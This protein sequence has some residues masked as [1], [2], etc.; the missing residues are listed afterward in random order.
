MNP[1]FKAPTL[2]AHIENLAKEDPGRA[3]LL[4]CNKEGA[5][6]NIFSRKQVKEALLGLASFFQNQGVKS[7]DVIGL[8]FSNSPLLL[9]INWAAWSLGIIT[10]PLDLKRDTQKEHDFKLTKSSASLLLCQKGVFSEEQ[11]KKFK[12]KVVEIDSS[13]L[14]FRGES[15]PFRKE[16]TQRALILFTSGTTSH[17]R[18]VMLS[19]YSLVTNADSIRKWFK[20]TNEDRFMV[21]LPLHHINSTTF[22]LATLLAGGSIAIPPEY[23][24]SMF[25][26]QIAATESTFT[27]IVQ[28]ICF[29]QL[30]RKEEFDAVKEKVRL[31]RIQIGSAP[32]VPSDVKAFMSSFHIPL[33]QGYGQTE[34]ALRVTGVPLD[35]DKKTYEYLTDTNSIGKSMDWA[36]VEIMG[37]DGEILKEGE[38]GEIVVKGDAVMEGYIDGGDHSKKG[39]FL[40]GD[41]GFYKIIQGERYFFLKGRKKEII[42]KGGINI[43]PVAVEDKLKRLSIDIDQAY[44]IGIEDKRYGEEV[45]AVVCFRKDVD[46]NE[47]SIRLKLSLFYGSDILSRYESPKYITSINAKDL[48]LTST[49]KV[50]R[51]VIK[52]NT[53]F[54]MFESSYLIAKNS[55]YSFFILQKTSP[56][57]SQAFSLYNYTWDPLA[58]SKENFNQFLQNMIVIVAVNNKD[59]VEGLICAVRTNLTEKQLTNVSYKDFLDFS[60]GKVMQKDGKAFVCIAISSSTYKKK[61]IPKVT[62]IPKKEE[63][64]E[65]L[66]AGRDSVF[67]FHQKPKGGFEKGASLV[68]VLPHTR[69]EDRRSLGYN[70]LLK[71]PTIAKLPKLS[72]NSSVAVNLIEVVMLLAKAL[73]VKTVYAYSRPADAAEYFKRVTEEL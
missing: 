13:V 46:F 38:E 68:S 60:S 59:R 52:K 9:M 42:I 71:Y 72:E 18:G 3:L 23:S 29:D 25:W 21:V 33:Y 19:L 58:V 44:V 31:A 24:N 51:S 6:E 64:E 10:I 37:E 34:T 56:Y 41:V 55:S 63:I 50:Q 7:G 40:T 65:Y 47:A 11:K 8:A 1:N 67:A 73:G 17:P 36:E 28:T 70:M 5:I 39:Y 12:I 54:S 26:K 69:P 15:L 49:G 22:C 43:S 35:L 61:D 16:T 62:R 48:P 53:L 14:S 57:L 4:D 66:R 20:I 45:A 30:S 27:S 2:I 32:V